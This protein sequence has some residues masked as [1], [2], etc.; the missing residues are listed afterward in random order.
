MVDSI[1]KRCGDVIV[2]SSDVDAEAMDSASR[3][4]SGFLAESCARRRAAPGDDLMS[5]LR[6]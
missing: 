1:L 4:L 5:V 6:E 2:Y 3:E